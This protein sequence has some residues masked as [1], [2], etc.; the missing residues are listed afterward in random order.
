M[1]QSLQIVDNSNAALIH[2]AVGCQKMLLV[3]PHTDFVNVLF[4]LPSI[5]YGLYLFVSSGS[6]VLL[7]LSGFTLLAWVVVSSQ[8]KH[9]VSQPVRVVDGRVWLG[10]RRLNLFP[11]SWSTKVR[12]VVYPALFPAPSS[13]PSTAEL[14]AWAL[15]VDFDGQP[16]PSPISPAKPHAIIVGQTG[17]G[18]TELIKRIIGA[19]QGDVIVIDFKGGYDYEPLTHPLRLFVGEQVELAIATLQ[20]RLTAPGPPTL[21]VVDELAEA[22]RQ[23]KL[24]QQL[25]SIAAKGRSLGVH[26]LGATQTMSGISRT[27]STNCHSR[28]ALRADPIDRSQLGFPTKPLQ[29]EGIGYAELS[30]GEIRGFLFPPQAPSI[31]DDVPGNPLFLRVATKPLSVPDEG[32]APSRQTPW[33]PR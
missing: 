13:Q 29:P 7:V 33:G 27:I 31:E 2:R 26:F 14:P 30:D 10:D 8:R 12:D 32:F 21:V 24:A 16:I 20:A 22:L 15:G 23:M 3:L 28:F 4:L 25:E 11:W 9:D 17:S 18:K 1:I 6:P 5:G 19:F